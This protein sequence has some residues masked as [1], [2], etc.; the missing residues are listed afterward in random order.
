MT[1]FLSR[2]NPNKSVFNKRGP[3][4]YVFNLHKNVQQI[5]ATLPLV[6]DHKRFVLN[7]K[8]LYEVRSVNLPTYYL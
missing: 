4:I 7:V 1:L 5:V 8:S 2:T 3:I 6:F